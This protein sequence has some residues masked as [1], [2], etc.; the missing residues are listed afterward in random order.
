MKEKI[1]QRAL[2]LGFDGCRFTT[3]APPDHA[4]EFQ[5]WISEHQHGEMAWLE[6][7][8]HKRV[9]PQQVLAGAKSVIVLATA[10]S[11]DTARDREQTT[12]SLGVIARYA[13]FA[14]Y[15]DVLA[16]PL[17]FLTAFIN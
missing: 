10:Y 12:D 16:A 1:R 5:R 11:A 17:K 6:R 7:N 3:A 14:D 2:E 9:E 4:A 15:H 13:R 8:A